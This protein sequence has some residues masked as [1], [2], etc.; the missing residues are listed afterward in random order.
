MHVLHPSLVATLRA[1]V[2]HREHAAALVPDRVGRLRALLGNGEVALRLPSALAGIA[3]VPVAW[4][5]GRELAGRARRDRVRGARRGQPAVRVVLAGGARLRA[6]RAHGGAR[7]ARAS[8]ARCASRR[9]A[10]PGGVRAGRRAGAADATTSPCSCSAGWRCGCSLDPRT[11]RRVAAGARGA[12]ASSALALLPLISA[13]GGHGTQWIGRWALPD[14]CR[15]SR[16]TTSPA[17]PA[18]RSATASSCSS[19]CRSSPAS[20]SG[21]W[22]C[23]RPPRRDAAPAPSRAGAR[24]SALARRRAG[25]LGAARGRSLPAC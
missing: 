11:R 22:R 21:A 16:S 14:A 20:R 10:P 9:R 2:A 6:V 12:R 7:D 18:R 24:G 8:C 4:A 13:Q 1:V 15:R 17:T 3:T 5:I 25:R 19:R 23:G